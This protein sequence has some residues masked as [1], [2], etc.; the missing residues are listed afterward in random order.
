MAKV[1]IHLREHELIA[2]NTLAQNQYRTSKAQ[3]ALIIRQELARLGLIEAEA[4]PQ[5]VIQSSSP[6]GESVIG[7]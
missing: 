5:P 1:I 6:A 2:L 4:Q 7:G 3:A